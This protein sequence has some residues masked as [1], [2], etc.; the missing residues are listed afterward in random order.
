L[1]AFRANTL[2]D[3]R[4]RRRCVV[5]VEAARL[6]RRRVVVPAAARF[7]ALALRRLGRLWLALF[8]AP[9]RAVFLRRLTGLLAEAVF[10]R[11]VADLRRVFLLR[12]TVPVA[13][14][15]EEADLRRVVFLRVFPQRAA[16]A[17]RAAAD[18]FALVLDL[19]TTIVPPKFV[20]HVL[21]LLVSI[22]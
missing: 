18:R 17:L 12:L 19:R 6:L 13:V 21:L 9:E 1:G 11:L 15:E 7:L 10:L 22:N 4:L 8:L 14:C 3:R 5:V 2:V 16:A 20:N